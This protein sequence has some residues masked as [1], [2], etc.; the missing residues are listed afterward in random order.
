MTGP[1]QTTGAPHQTMEVQVTGS[2]VQL[3]TTSGFPV[4]LIYSAVLPA[5]SMAENGAVWMIASS[6]DRDNEE[7][8]FYPMD[9]YDFNALLFKNRLFI[10]ANDQWVTKESCIKENTNED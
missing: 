1:Y 10:R 9:N 5:G 3:E 2:T 6:V 7:L 4:P 8:K